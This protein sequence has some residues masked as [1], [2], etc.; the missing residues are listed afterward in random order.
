[1]ERASRLIRSLCLP[2]ETVNLEELVRNAWPVAVGRKIAVHTRAT[3]M[4]RT[5]LLV[6][7]EDAVWQ[8]QLFALTPFV[9][10][11]LD[12]ALGQGVVEDIEFRVMPL[13][14]EPQHAPRSAPG[15]LFAPDEAD[16][17]ADPV[18]RVIYKASRKKALA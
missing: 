6:E 12:K 18:L 1:M 5:R 7:V 14:R 9:L 11:N 4:V 16:R 17:I 15:A 10:K 13:R 2:G 3:R 8:R